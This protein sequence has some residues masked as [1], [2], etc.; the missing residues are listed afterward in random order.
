M[1]AFGSM[2]RFSFKPAAGGAP[3]VASQWSLSSEHSLLMQVRCGDTLRVDRGTVWIGAE[4]SPGIVEL[5][6]G[7]IHTA[8][9]DEVLRMTGIDAPHLTVLSQGPVKVSTQADYGGWRYQP[10]VK[11][12]RRADWH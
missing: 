6:A 10:P 5:H 1:F 8:G 2:F 11:R 3:R 4:A 7:G 12:A 9:R